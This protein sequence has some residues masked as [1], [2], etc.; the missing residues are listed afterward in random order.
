MR[1]LPAPLLL[2]DSSSDQLLLALVRGERS[3][4]Q[5]ILP[6]GQRLSSLLLPEIEALLKGEG[7]ERGALRGIAVGQGPGS[8]MGLRTGAVVAQSCAYA[9]QIPYLPFC[10]LLL[11]LPEL[12]GHFVYAHETRGGDFYL[13]EGTL[14]EGGVER[15]SLMG[16]APHTALSSHVRR[17]GALVVQPDGWGG[18]EERL[19]RGEGLCAALRAQL[20]EAGS[21]QLASPTAAPVVERVL[22]V[23]GTG[24]EAIVPPPLIYLH[25]A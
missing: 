15:Y 2:I 1:T 3:I 16:R 23:L 13:V 9:L 5:R 24:L 19:Q 21:V 8:Y 12:Q 7:V 6:H 22:G 17:G 11:F 4:A 10:S 14:C 25:H 20:P 18:S